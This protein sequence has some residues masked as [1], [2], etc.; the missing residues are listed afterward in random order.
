MRSIQF[1][2]IHSCVSQDIP[3]LFTSVA[4][5]TKIK[6]RFPDYIWNMQRLPRSLFQWNELNAFI[7]TVPSILSENMLSKHIDAEAVNNKRNYEFHSETS[8]YRI[9]ILENKINNKQQQQKP[10]ANS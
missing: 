1:D 2:S 6:F 8:I 7:S 10:T 3:I 5:N 9:W 4:K